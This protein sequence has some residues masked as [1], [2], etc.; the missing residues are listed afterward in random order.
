MQTYGNEPAVGNVRLNVAP[1]AIVP[2]FHVPS[3][4]VAVCDVASLFVHVTV[5]PTAIVTGFGA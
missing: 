1:G 4:A 5:P 2:E 3:A